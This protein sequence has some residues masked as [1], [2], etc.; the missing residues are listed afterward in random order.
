MELDFLFK[1]PVEGISD[2]IIKYQVY[3]SA[4]LTD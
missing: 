4:N 3:E 2:L 1:L